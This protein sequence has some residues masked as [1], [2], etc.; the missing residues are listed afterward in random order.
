MVP[1]QWK[2]FLCKCYSWTL[3][4]TIRMWDWHQFFTKLW[5][6]NST[7][8]ICFNL[9]QNLFLIISE[10]HMKTSGRDVL[11]HRFKCVTL[12]RLIIF[13]LIINL[14]ISYLF[15]F[16]L[17][18]TG[19]AEFAGIKGLRWRRWIGVGCGCWSAESLIL[20]LLL[21]EAVRYFLDL[22][23]ELIAA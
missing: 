12:W 5:Q 13:L 2:K 7:L 18:G 3:L 16:W 23:W 19:M 1:L 6:T 17:T 21:L 20:S 8:L 11:T 10:G 4:D 14:I 9:K 15:A 22:F